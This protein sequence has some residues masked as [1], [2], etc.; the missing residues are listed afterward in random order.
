MVS[1][2]LIGLSII[3]SLIV[4]TQKSLF[5]YGM[6]SSYIKVGKYGEFFRQVGLFQFI[7]GN[8]LHLVM[9]S[10]FLYQA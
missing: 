1:L 2:T 9:N 6:S 8:M 4:W 7:H 10:Y 3:V 5:R